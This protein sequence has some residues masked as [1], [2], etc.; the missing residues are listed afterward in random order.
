MTRWAIADTG[1]LV[2]L[3]DRH[4]RHHRWA[5]EQIK[6]L[7]PPLL[8]CEPVLVEAIFLLSPLPAGQDA[9]FDHLENGVLRIAFHLE[10]NLTEI[11]TLRRKYR[12][13]PISLADA[14]V[15]RMAELFDNHHVLTLDSDF[16]VYRKH[17]R[18][19]L[20]VIHPEGEHQ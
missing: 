4:E 14:C 13:R 3:L 18:K 2:A 7:A 6:N 10:E 9:I 15:V 11:K 20:G 8:V 16:S 19:P 1:P 12:D 17:G 5:V